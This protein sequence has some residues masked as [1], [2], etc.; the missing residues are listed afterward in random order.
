MSDDATRQ[1]ERD[2]ANDPTAALALLRDHNRVGCP[3]VPCPG[4]KSIIARTQEWFSRWATML[5]HPQGRFI[6]EEPHLA[7][8]PGREWMRPTLAEMAGM[9]TEVHY[10]QEVLKLVQIRIG[11]PT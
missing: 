2:A 10:H 4:C 9:Q 8:R 5:V 3:M 1:H 7:E 6:F 11:S